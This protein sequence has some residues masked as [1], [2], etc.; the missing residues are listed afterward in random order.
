MGWNEINEAQDRAHKR[1]L[2][3]RDAQARCAR[4]A[5]EQQN[6][7]FERLAKLRC[8]NAERLESLARAEWLR[9]EVK[10]EAWWTKA[11]AVA[12][13]LFAASVLAVAIGGVM[14][15]T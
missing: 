5:I 1:E 13:V 3:A 12:L 9:D 10:A 4:A 15:L 2:E 8:D 11:K 7:H 14:V 6:L